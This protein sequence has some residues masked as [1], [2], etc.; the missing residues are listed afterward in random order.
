[1]APRIAG[2]IW[3]I[4]ITMSLTPEEEALFNIPNMVCVYHAG[5]SRTKKYNEKPHYHLY[6]NS[7]EEVRQKK[8]QDLLKTN[9]I[10]RK[11]YV[12]KNDFWSTKT[13]FNYN[14]ESYWEYVWADYPSK[15]QRLVFWNISE[16]QLPI[17]MPM[18]L[19]LETPGNI[20]ATGPLDE[21]RFLGKAKDS[22]KSSLEKQQ[23]FLKHVKEYY[24]G[25]DLNTVTAKKV[26][27]RLYDYCGQNGFT[28]E[29]CCY[30]WVNYVIANIHTEETYKESRRDFTDRIHRRFF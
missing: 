3:A 10:V 9:E 12:S 21:H 28:T 5:G 2:T 22:K 11:Y 26:I 27:K 14:L 24:E 18:D 17:P 30:T 4:R 8:V 13:A 23:K 16:P 19:I 1:M 15:S 7:G 6:Y 29:A 20:I 25:K